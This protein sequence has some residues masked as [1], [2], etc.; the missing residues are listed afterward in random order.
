[1]LIN[2]E[3]I[4]NNLVKILVE[5]NLKLSLCES[6]TG[7]LISKICTD[8]DGSSQWFSGSIVSYSNEFKQI[9]GVKKTVLEK[10][11]AVSQDTADEMSA[12]TLKLTKADICLSITGIAGPNGGSKEKPVGTVYFSYIDKFGF[13]AKEKCFFSG[14]RN[15]IRNLAAIKGIQIILDCVADIK[16][17]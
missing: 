16:S 5:K 14:T 9:I 15:E 13:K 17:Q 8:L 3:K 2:L 4:L 6:C 11:G 7:G 1:M 10:F 12:S